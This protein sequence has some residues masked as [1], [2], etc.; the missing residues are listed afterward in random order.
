MHHWRVVW[1]LF[2]KCSPTWLCVCWEVYLSCPCGLGN[3]R[4][5]SC[6]PI[7]YV[8]L[9]VLRL[10]ESCR[11]QAVDISREISRKPLAGGALLD[12][13]MFYRTKS[14]SQREVRVVGAVMCSVCYPRVS[15]SVLCFTV[16]FTSKRPAGEPNPLVKVDFPLQKIGSLSLSFSQFFFFFVVSAGC[17]RSTNDDHKHATIISY[18]VK[19]PSK[20]EANQGLYCGVVAWPTRLAQGRGEGKEAEGHLQGGRKAASVPVLPQDHHGAQVRMPWQSTNLL[21]VVVG[22]GAGV[23]VG[24]CCCCNKTKKGNVFD[25]QQPR[26]GLWNVTLSLQRKYLRGTQVLLE[27]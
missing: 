18:H 12:W 9:Q 15:P 23:V 1:M 6:M 13:H 24:C 14:Q 7:Y 3:T 21:V 25:F 10:Q 22:G 5:S 19:D 17:S 4:V 2:T 8:K 20:H 16:C 26:N 27:I 11:K